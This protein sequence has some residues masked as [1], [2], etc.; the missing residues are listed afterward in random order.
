[1]STF[2]DFRLKKALNNA[3]ADLEFEKPTPIQKESFS[4]VLSG[5]DVL[6]IA[7]TGTGKTLAYMLP[8]LEELTFSK[9]MNPRILV[10]VPTKELVIQVAEEV[11]RLTKYMTVRTIAVYGGVNAKRQHAAL[12]NGADI[13]VATPGRLYDLVLDQAFSLK[14]IKKLV[15]DEVDVMLDLGF[16]HQLT[17]I[18]E[19]IPDN[20]QNIMF[21]ATMTNNV[22]DLIHSFFKDVTKISIAVSGTP[23]ENISQSCYQ[24]ENFYTKVNLL[25]HLLKDKS[26]YQKVL[27][28][29]SNK[30]G[31][32]RVFTALEE[33]FADD[34]CIVHSNKSQNY[35]IRS[36]Q[37]FDAGIN[38]ILVSTDVMTRG[39]DF[40][41]VSHVIN[42]DTPPFPENY[43]HRIGRTGRAEKE[44]SS[45]LFYLEEEIK[46][47]EA[48]EKLMKYTIPVNPF[49]EEVEI[50]KELTPEERPEELPSKNHGRNNKQ[51]ERGAATHEKKEKNSKVNQGGSYKRDMAKKYKK[52]QTRGDKT[53]HKRQKRG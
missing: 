43:M 34:I 13:I 42:F 38:R 49:P 18:M 33:T 40:D 17:R 30:R 41:Q 21:S 46:S 39:L 15:I 36:V 23:L 1:M 24:V 28:F 27:V 8:L 50:S 19:M 35:R 44:G 6:G 10:M 7:Q 53:Y 29:V 48:I 52:A 14:G 32:D 20:R 25:A 51:V 31:A 3:I 26:V 11:E 22:Q 45:V 16:I 9:Q 37:D 5:K 12:E 4:V 2:H 47:K